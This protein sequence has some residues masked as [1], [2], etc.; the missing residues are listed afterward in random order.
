MKVLSIILTSP[1]GTSVTIVDDPGKPA[2][3]WGCANDDFLVT[4]DDEGTGNVEDTCT[5]SPAISGTLIPNN[6]LSAFDG[7]SSQG[8]WTLQLNDSYTQADSGTLNNWSLIITAEATANEDTAAPVISL[9]GDNPLELLVGSTFSEPGYL[10]TDNV[11]GNI[12]GSV[13]VNSSALNTNA[14]GSYSV[15][16]NISDTAGNNAQTIT[17]TVNVAAAADTNAPII[18]LLGDSPLEIPIGNGYNEPGYL[19]TDNIDG[20]I[21][22]SVSVDASAV[23][24]NAAG[25][26]LVIYTVFDAAGNPATVTRWI[27]VTT[28]PDTTAPVINLLGNNPYEILIGGVYS[29]PGYLATDSVDGDITGSVSVDS[30]AIDNNTAGSYLVTYNV[31]DAA[32]N[33]ASTV[34]RTV[35][36]MAADSTAPVISLLGND[37]LEIAAGSSYNEPGYSAI[38]NVDGNITASVSV[39]SS[40]VNTSIAGSY[41]VTYDVSDTAGNDAATV[42]R[43]VNVTAAPDTTAPT[44]TL[45]G[46]NPLIILE[47]SAYSEP[48]YSASDNVDGNIS[49]SVSINSSAVNTS[50]IGSYSVTYDVSDAAG[51]VATTVTRTVNV[52]SATSTYEANPALNVG[53]ASVSTTLNIAND[54]QIADLNVFIDMQH[55]YPG[56]VSIILTSPSGTSVTM[57]DG[58]GKPASTWGC[59]NDDFLVTLDDEGTNNVEDACTSAPAVSGTLIPNNALSAFDGESTQGTWTLQLDDS[60]TQADTG[61]LNS[62]SLNITAETTSSQDTTAPVIALSGNNPLAIALGSVYNEPGYSATD[63]IDG[64]ITASVSVDSS[65]VNTSIA[66]SYL[67]TYNVADAAG[68]TALTVLR[69]VNVT[70]IIDT[71]APVITLTGSN[72]LIILE[73]GTYSE[74]GYSASDNIDGNITSS[75]SV[76]ANAVNTNVIGSYLVTYDVN[77][78]AGNDAITVTRTINVVSATSSHTENPALNV[79]AASI[80]TTLNITEDIQIA[81][82]NIFIDMPHDYPGDV[83]MILI[84]PSGTS[85]TIIDGPG[86]PASTWGCANDDFLVTLDDEGTGNAEDTCTSAP[87]ISGTLIPNNALSA[88]DGESAQGTWTLQLDDAYT[89][90]D[91]GTLNSWSLNITAEL[92]ATADTTAPILTLVGNAVV[93]LQTGDSFNDPGAIANDNIDGDITNSIN[94][95]G[96]IDLSTNGSYVLTYNVQDAAGNSATSVSRTINVS[97]ASVPAIFT[98][99][100]V[101]TTGGSHTIETSHAGYTGAGFVNYNGEGFMEYTFDGSATPYD[102]TI[103]Y[104]LDGNNRP[105]EVILNGT[106]LGTINFP[107]TAG[108]ATW[109]TTAPFSITPLAGTNTLRL[110]TSG[111]SGANVDS[112]TLTPQ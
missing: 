63:N 6:A 4:L 3:T 9:L 81:D 46:S 86:K 94:V 73:G 77:D 24:T 14:I 20:D 51:N 91:T 99:A 26:Y 21:T 55:D 32:G 95:S 43:T 23:N 74:P 105:L 5:N 41:S 109:L 22:S 70:A 29:E 64:N 84:S 65:T 67:V 61:T 48:G 108:W 40:A 106:S 33:A 89:Q 110:Q 78:A 17:R 36:V 103:R 59:A 56:D 93:N 69:T 111:S 100:E 112:Y 72:P 88:F 2:S 104:A 31:S 11:D 10:A 71:T 107:S 66:G 57:V 15:T 83:S 92:T 27:N 38:D 35:N 58:P 76:N 42:T 98:E 7:E 82:L 50:V 39:D 45:S 75:V 34:T 60:Y 12:T 68:N 49:S 13:V 54:I 25:S 62:W 52:I 16:Y 18:S 47:G 102:L 79:G 85:V 80:S 97:S 30:S 37:P 28:G 1:S 8:T 96:T 87:A 101:G 53:A 44:I 90:A 19:A